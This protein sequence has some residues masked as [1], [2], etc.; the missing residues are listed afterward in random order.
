MPFH[1]LGIL[2]S[3][4]GSNMVALIDAAQTGM[5]PNA[6]VA[7]VISDQRTAAGSGESTSARN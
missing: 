7:V 3:G 4:R 1:R 5:I 6:E 2:I